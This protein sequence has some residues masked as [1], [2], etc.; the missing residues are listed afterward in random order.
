MSN[1]RPGLHAQAWINATAAVLT[2]MTR[3]MPRHD[4]LG[5]AEKSPDSERTTRT[6]LA[7]SW[8]IESR[9]KLLETLTWL[10]T[11]GHQAKYGEAREIFLSPGDRDGEEVAFFVKHND[12]LGERGLTAWDQVRLIAVA[13]WGYLAGF[14]SEQEAWDFVT[15]AAKTLQRTY[16]SWNELGQAYY[17]GTVW[18]NEEAGSGC[19]R[20]VDQLLGSP[21]SLW[22]LIPWSLDLDM[23]DDTGKVNVHLRRAASFGVGYLAM[24]AVM[25]AL[26]GGVL[27]TVGRSMFKDVHQAV[28]DISNAVKDSPTPSSSDATTPDK[29]GA[30]PSLTANAKVSH[31]WDGKSPLNCGGTTELKIENVQA[32]L[33]AGPAVIAGGNC[34]L[35]L[36]GVSLRAPVVLQVMGNARVTLEDCEIHGTTSAISASGNGQVTLQG[37]HIDGPINKSGAAQVSG[38]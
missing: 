32:S 10:S 11:E 34:Q 9:E 29:P 37:S 21:T 8:G 25:V 3:R 36:K 27:F 23:R 17:L 18:W 35:T 33:S 15:P 30:H 19:K 14:I 2:V 13:G 20:I 24:G 28:S 7:N 31:G 38:S 16:K 4:L 5:G 22:R 6:I 26:I 1:N 12:P